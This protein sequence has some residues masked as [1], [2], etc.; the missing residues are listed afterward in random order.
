MEFAVSDDGRN[1]RTVATIANDISL[2]TAGAVLK[3]F[4]ADAPRLSARYVR[5]AA[6]NIGLCPD[7]HPDQGEKAWIFADEIIVD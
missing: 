7:R 3:E 2:Q 1:Y 5:V 4:A 6:K